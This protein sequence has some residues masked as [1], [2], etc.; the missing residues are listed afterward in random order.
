M[1]DDQD[2]DGGTDVDA[3]GDA[4]RD[5]DGA[6]AIDE[7]TAT[8]EESATNEE[9]ATEDAV[10][11]F[12]SAAADVYDDYDRGYVDADAALSVLDDRIDDL[13]TSV[14]TGEGRDEE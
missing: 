9:S 11:E 4:S 2:I 13:R 12:L 1:S 14:E 10:S 8:D 5:A 3:D 7:S 6:T